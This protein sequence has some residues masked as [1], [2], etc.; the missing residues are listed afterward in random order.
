MVRQ[1]CPNGQCWCVCLLLSCWSLLH[2]MLY[3][4]RTTPFVSTWFSYTRRSRVS[5]LDFF[6]VVVVGYS[7][8]GVLS[9]VLGPIS[10]LNFA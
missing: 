1:I 9:T 5:R 4:G 2:Q 7:E 3:L 8:S 10:I 6:V